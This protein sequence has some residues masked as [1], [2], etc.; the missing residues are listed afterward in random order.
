LALLELAIFWPGNGSKV[1][2]WL[3][4]WPDSKIGEKFPHL[5]SFSLNSDTTLKRAVLD[6]NDENTH[7]ML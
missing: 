7:D 1:G 4:I 6:F 5:C 3:D 2:L